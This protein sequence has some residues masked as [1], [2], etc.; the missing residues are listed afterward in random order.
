[1]L[2][3]TLEV[4]GT[5]GYNKIHKIVFYQNE[6]E[7][8]NSL[9]LILMKVKTPTSAYNLLDNVGRLITRKQADNTVNPAPPLFELNFKSKLSFWR[10]INNRRKDLKAGMHPDVLLSKN[11][12]LISKTPRAMTQGSTLFHKPDSTLYYLPNPQPFQ[13]P[14]HDKNKQK[15]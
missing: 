14:H 6:K 5:G 10:Y 4:S 15:S 1:K 11:G 13:N 12:T 8:R 2:I 7:I 3:Y 9:G